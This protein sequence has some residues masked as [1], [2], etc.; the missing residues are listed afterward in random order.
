MNKL[1]EPG[2]LYKTVRDRLWLDTSEPIEKGTIL[3]FLECEVS[4][5]VLEPE[6]FSSY[7]T[8]WLM[9]GRDT[10]VT[11]FFPHTIPGAFNKFFRKI[12]WGGNLTNDN[13]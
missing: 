6:T 5:S 8:M 2:K 13:E 11:I 7:S 4:Q 3:M 10:K 1:L 9:E 12:E